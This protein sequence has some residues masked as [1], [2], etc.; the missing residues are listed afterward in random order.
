MS[1]QFKVAI[2]GGGIAGLCTSI[3]LAQKNISVVLFEKNSYPKHKVCG[4]YISLETKAFLKSIDVDIDALQ[5]PIISNLLFTNING[6]KFETNLPLGGFGISRYYLDELL[7][8]IA[9]KYGVTIFENTTITSVK[10]L[11]S[12]AILLDNKNV[13]HTSELV[14]HAYGKRSNLDVL[15]NRKFIQQ[16]HSANKNFV[17]IKYHIRSNKINSNAI[18]LHLFGAGYC[19]ISKVENDITC[20]C[21]L[22]TADS[23]QKA[24]SIKNLEEQ[25]LKK[26]EYLNEIFIDAEHLWKEPL[27]IAQI[28]FA[29]KEVHVG[30][31][32]Y[33]G[34]ASSLITPL[35]GNGMSMAMHQSYILANNTLQYF[36]NK[37]TWDKA[38]QQYETQWN[39]AFSRRIKIGLMLQNII[40]NPKLANPA[41][42]VL[43]NSKWLRQ[44]VIKQT[45]GNQ[46]FKA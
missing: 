46:W 23:L 16:K 26:N 35:C 13:E 43:R 38:L 6:N 1:K 41:I 7:F 22:T 24:G 10:Q 14:I 42:T 34:D 19:G 20:L 33:V 9:K 37:I 29:K 36:A 3:Q 25:L 17:G 45:H 12:K 8:T 27:T 15:S 21:Y 11:G 44:F 28:S 31:M 40:Y 39:S 5:L 30:N 2:I 4:E 18:G 32:P